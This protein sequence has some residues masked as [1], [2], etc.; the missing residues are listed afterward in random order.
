MVRRVHPSSASTISSDP[1][2]HAER[3]GSHAGSCDS[4]C[5]VRRSGLGEEP[6]EPLL[7]GIREPAAA[8]LRKFGEQ[9]VMTGP[10]HGLGMLQDAGADHRM[11]RD[12]PAGAGG[13]QGAAAS[14]RIRIT[15]T[16]SC[17]AMSSVA[18]PHI[19]LSRAGE[20]P[21]QDDPASSWQLAGKAGRDASEL[22]GRERVA[23]MSR[24]AF[25][26]QYAQA[27]GGVAIEVFLPLSPAHERAE[28]VR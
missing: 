25:R 26:L 22:V 4:W 5:A 17:S 13:L 21:E 15:G 9:A 1:W 6:A 7:E 8:V 19:S 18:S 10:A 27:D 2:A 28:P 12:G 14:G 23:R 16:P 11:E 3:P 24:I 20:Q